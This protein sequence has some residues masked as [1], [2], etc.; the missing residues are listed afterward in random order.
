MTWRI[1]SYSEIEVPLKPYKPCYV[2]AIIEDSK[3]ER[4]MAQVE[5]GAKNISVGVEGDVKKVEGPNGEINLFTP[6]AKAEKQEVRKV[7]LVTGSARGIGRAIAAELAKDGFD[8]VVNDVCEEGDVK[9]VLD[10]IKKL[11]RNAIYVKAD[12]SELTQ[13]DS[14]IEKTV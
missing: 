4:I 14:M 13:V 5:G 2:L 11:G 9:E 3:G 7:A 10:E 12:V 1:V 8:V 6:K